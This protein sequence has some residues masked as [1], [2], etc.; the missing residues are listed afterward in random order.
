MLL[1]NVIIKKWLITN[2]RF[3]HDAIQY[4]L[5]VGL[6]LVGWDFP[7]KGSLKELIE[8]S[9]LYP[10]TCITNFTKAEISRLLE[11]NIIICKTISNNINLLD[12]LNIP[13][14]R[15]ESI[16]EQCHTLWNSAVN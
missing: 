16:I 2:T 7:A 1:L 8:F 4:G 15:R 5:C 14:Q 11:K 6:H 13:K 3:T 12:E 10:I 9:G